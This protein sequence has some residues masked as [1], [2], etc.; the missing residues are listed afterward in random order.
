VARELGEDAYIIS[1][2]RVENGVEV[3]ASLTPPR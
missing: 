1:T 2:K 3:V